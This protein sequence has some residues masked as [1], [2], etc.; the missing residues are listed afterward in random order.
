[1]ILFLYIDYRILSSTNHQEF[2]VPKPVSQQKGHICNR[3]VHTHTHKS[4]TR[5]SQTL[6]S[7]LSKVNLF[8]L[9]IQ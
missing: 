2:E 6:L 8:Q 3:S 7:F 4:L 5:P 9:I 1:M